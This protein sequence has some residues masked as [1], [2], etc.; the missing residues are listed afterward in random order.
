MHMHTHVPTH[1]PATV[2]QGNVSLRTA[3]QFSH[4]MVQLAVIKTALAHARVQH[5]LTLGGSSTTASQPAWQPHV[6]EPGVLVQLWGSL[7][8]SAKPAAQ[9]STSDHG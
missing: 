5:V 9:S 7:P 8:Q 4:H 1:M 6:Y 3:A 2:R